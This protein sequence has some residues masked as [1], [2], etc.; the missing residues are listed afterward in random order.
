[1]DFYVQTPA[2]RQPQRQVP[3]GRMPHRHHMIE[4]KPV[5]GR[6]FSQRLDAGGDIFKCPRPAAARIANPPVLRRPHRIAQISYGPAH[7]SGMANAKLVQPASAVNENNNRMRTRQ[8]GQPQLAKL[9]SI[10]AIAQAKVSHILGQRHNIGPRHIQ[11]G[12]IMHTA[13]P[14]SQNNHEM[15]KG[16]MVGGTRIE[17]VATTMST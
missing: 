14:G 2:S 13:F 16:K 3:A 1:M 5:L 15:F 9:Q 7:R 17:L 12:R 11:G 6:K 10:S 4:I 8:F